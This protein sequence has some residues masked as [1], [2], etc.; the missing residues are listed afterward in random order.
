MRGEMATRFLSLLVLLALF[1]SVALAQQIYKWKDKEGQW[2]FS[3]APPAEVRAERLKGLDIPPKS[4]QPITVPPMPTSPNPFEK[5]S[6]P[7]SQSQTEKPKLASSPQKIVV[8]FTRDGGSIIVEGIVNGKDKVEF[9]LDTEAEGTLIPFDL[10]QQSGVKIDQGVLMPHVGI[11]GVVW[12][13]V[14]D[15]DSLKVGEAEVKNLGVSIARQRILG[16]TRRGLLGADFLDDFRVDIQYDKNQIILE[17]LQGPYAGYPAKWWQKRFRHYDRLKK[18]YKKLRKESRIRMTASLRQRCQ[19][20]R[21][22]GAPAPYECRIVNGL[23]TVEAKP[24]NLNLRA[25]HAGVPRK[26]RK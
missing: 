24:A 19:S 15:I 25:Y 22:T 20:A 5:P 13:P 7:L 12:Y 8:P 17:R 3:D 6:V 2:H 23:R 11:G 26:F 1:F 9:I 21:Q 4:A 16:S 18:F 14:V 10:V